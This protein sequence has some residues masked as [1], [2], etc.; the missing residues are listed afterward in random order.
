MKIKYEKFLL[1]NG[2]CLTE[3]NSEELKDALLDL[4]VNNDSLTL[5]MTGGTNGHPYTVNC[6]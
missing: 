3:C 1:V 5:V 6:I 4:V 2:A